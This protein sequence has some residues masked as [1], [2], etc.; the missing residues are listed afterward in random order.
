MVGQSVDIYLSTSDGT[1]E[2]GNIGTSDAA[3]STDKLNNLIYVGSVVVDTTA[4]NT[5]IISSGFVKIDANYCSVV[6]HN[7]TADALHSSTSAQH[8]SLTPVPDQIQ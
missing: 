4:T 8:I 1:D 2:D 5:D 7:N 6:I 3:G